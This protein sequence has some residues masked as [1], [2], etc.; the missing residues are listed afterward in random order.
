MIS[1]RQA[2]FSIFLLAPLAFHAI[3]V[4]A[5][6]PYK[7]TDA[8]TADPDTL[9]LRLGLIQAERKSGD[10]ETL[11]PLLRA[12]IGLA[13]RFEIVTEFEYDSVDHEFGDGALGFK[14]IPLFGDVSYGLE[15][16]LLLPIRPG[17]SGVGIE[18]QF[19]ATWCKPDYRVHINAGG[20]HDPRTLDTAKGWRASMLAEMTNYSYRPGIE[21]FTRQESGQDIEVRLGAGFVQSVGGFEI[22]SA[23]HFGLTGKAPDVL[24]NFWISTKL[25][26]RR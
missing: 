2:G 13:N 26:L 19:L 7:T 12:N 22:R 25:P 24:F 5:F 20:F 10:T 16:L 15:T 14:W 6:P 1:I 9:E 3:P 4:A 11:S 23:V 17:D 21:L 8:D 18:S